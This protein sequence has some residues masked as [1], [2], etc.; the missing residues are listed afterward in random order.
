[1][2]VV[3]SYEVWKRQKNGEWKIARWISAPE[4]S[5]RP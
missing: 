5:V 4:P 2:A 1:V 3:R